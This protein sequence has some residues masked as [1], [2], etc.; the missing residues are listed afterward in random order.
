VGYRLAGQTAGILI[1]GPESAVFG[2]TAEEAAE[3]DELR[4]VRGKAPRAEDPS[5]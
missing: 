1:D 2:I 3:I 5:D 4:K